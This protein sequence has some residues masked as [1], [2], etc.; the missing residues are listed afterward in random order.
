MMA[1]A[2][3]NSGEKDQIDTFHSVSPHTR[4]RDATCKFVQRVGEG[5]SHLTRAREMQ[6]DH[7]I[8]RLS[9]RANM[10]KAR[11]TKGRAE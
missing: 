3:R 10:Q 9:A 11:P 5:V 1:R 2:R 7:P 6:R 4:A 8:V